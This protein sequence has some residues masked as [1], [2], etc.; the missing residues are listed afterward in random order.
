MLGCWSD[1]FHAPETVKVFG[2]MPIS[3]AAVGWVELAKPS[4][5]A[6][7]LLPIRGKRT[8]DLAVDPPPDL[9]LEIGI[10]TRPDQ[11]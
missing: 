5:Q 4:V 8:I 3:R 7:T 2:A 9:A 1:G 6:L 10:T 11:P